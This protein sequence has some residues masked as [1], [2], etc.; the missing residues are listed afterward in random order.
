M[1]KLIIIISIYSLL[2]FVTLLSCKKDTEANEIDTNFE[3]TYISA[4]GWCNGSYELNI[5][6]KLATY[7]YNAV[8]EN[9]PLKVERELSN[10]EI[11]ELK[12]SELYAEIKLL[13]IDDC[14]VCVD[15]CDESIYFIED[16]TT[17]FIRFRNE[18][19]IA[20]LSNYLSRIRDLFNTFNNES[21]DK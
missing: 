15:G 10:S 21:L 14:G 13:E 20:H 11:E 1:K 9:K 8:C 4:C 16:G 3:F 12:L 2:F 17:F 6:N 19:D 7:K 5:V 18:E